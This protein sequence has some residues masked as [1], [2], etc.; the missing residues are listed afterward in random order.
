MDPLVEVQH[1]RKEYG[2]TV[3]VDDVSLKVYPGTCL[4]LLGPNGAGK[5]TTIEIIED[6]IPPTEGQVLFKG[7]VR[8]NSY[9]EKVG[10]QFQ[11]T[12]LLNYL[13]VVET[14]QTFSKLFSSTTDT[15]DL[16]ERCDLVS[17]K[18]RR[19]DQLSGGQLQ[20]LLLALALINDP[21]LV[22]LDEPSTGLDPQSRRN[23][24]SL[25]ED[26]KKQQKTIIMTT[27]SMEE[28]QHLCD[29]IAIMDKGLIIA[30]GTPE[31]LITEHCPEEAVS[32]PSH[33]LPPDTSELP[34]TFDNQG[35]H[36]DRVRI[37][38]SDIEQTV[39]QLSEHNISLTG[40]TVHS[41]TLEDVFLK[42]TGRRLRD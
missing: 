38:T 23:L 36:N 33:S 22:F 10:I 13:S 21:E 2:Q 1:I 26:I 24:W 8:D 9:H 37:V 14:L 31:S 29:R 20:R 41:P 16:L 32:L 27:H 11:H 35:N 5:T 30:E 4:G 7:K 42:L 40:M 19:N 6:I 28:A 3:A 12:S 25:V 17:I 15:H 18:K 34:F 39:K